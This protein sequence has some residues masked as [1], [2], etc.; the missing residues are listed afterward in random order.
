MKNKVLPHTAPEL[1]VALPQ[2]NNQVTH[3]HL[4]GKN[5]KE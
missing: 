3:E 2:T 4:I 1:Y 5:L